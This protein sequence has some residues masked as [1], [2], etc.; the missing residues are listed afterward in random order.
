MTDTLL[1]EQRDS[2]LWLT[3]NRPQ[4]LNAMNAELVQA[5]RETFEDLKRRSDI[6]IVVLRASGKAFCAGLD[7]QSDGWSGDE[8]PQALMAMQTGI[9]D[10]YRAMRRCPQPIIALVQGAACGG[11]FSLALAADI[12]IAELL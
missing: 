11:G 1:K 5:L 7:L 9:S 3:L 8:S 10:I 6:R 2:T 4:S 12:R